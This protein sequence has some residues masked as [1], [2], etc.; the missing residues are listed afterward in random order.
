MHAHGLHPTPATKSQAPGLHRSQCSPKVRVGHTQRPVSGS[1]M[2]PGR[3]H[4]SHAGK[5]RRISIS[6]PSFF[7]IFHDRY[8]G[9]RS[10]KI[11][12]IRVDTCRNASRPR[13]ACSN[14]GPRLRGRKSCTPRW[15]RIR[16]GRIQ[17][18]SAGP[19]SRP[20]RTEGEDRK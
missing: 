15:G 10:R 20:F 8:L 12:N 13:L 6:F 14:T 19:R 18:P 3:T 16:R 7:L 5:Q 4:G 11:R 9:T 2:W 1:Q 17:L